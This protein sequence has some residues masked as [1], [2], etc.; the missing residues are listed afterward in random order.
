MTS[1]QSL[2]SRH[3]DG[4]SP[5]LD[6]SINAL[7]DLMHSGDTLGGTIALTNTSDRDAVMIYRCHPLQYVD[8]VISNPESKLISKYCYG[9]LFSPSDREHSLIIHPG[10]TVSFPVSLFAG[11]DKKDRLPGQYFVKAIVTYNGVATESNTIK[12]SIAGD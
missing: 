12:V 8:V 2:P 4:R 6:C 10:E 7:Q 1:G 11:I 9:H 5:H 3:N